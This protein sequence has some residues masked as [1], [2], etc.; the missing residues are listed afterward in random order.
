MDV[1]DSIPEGYYLKVMNGGWS[2]QR[3]W[4]TYHFAQISARIPDDPHI[5]LV[6][7]GSGPGAFFYQHK[8]RA[9]KVGID[10][11]QSQIN[12]VKKIMP[13]AKWISGDIE[14]MRLPKADYVV[15]TQVLEHLPPDT[16]ILR[17]I[18]NSLNDN[19][20]VIITTP[21]YK[22]LWPVVEW[23]WER[24]SP[25]KYEEQHIN[26]QTLKSLRKKAEESG[27]CVVEM[28]TLFLFTPFVALASSKLA[29]AL[30]P[31][32]EKIIGKMG[33]ILIAVLEKN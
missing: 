13:G 16:K 6:D 5:K 15:M 32:E 11:A 22:S 21:N 25:V 1:Y 2:L 14:K 12:Y 26:P 31:F 9:K 3:F 18:F 23:F 28:K 17:H 29:H 30:A 8:K 20:R 7:L 10:F 4:H 33:M 27:F 19:G 24:V